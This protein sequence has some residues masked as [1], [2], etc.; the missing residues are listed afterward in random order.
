MSRN[1]EGVGRDGASCACILLFHFEDRTFHLRN[2]ARMASEEEKGHKIDL[3]NRM[4]KF[5]MDNGTCRQQ[6]IA[7]YFGENAGEPLKKFF[8][9]KKKLYV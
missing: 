2:I 6:V 9:E 7:E 8:F 3:L 4:S 1:L 5:C